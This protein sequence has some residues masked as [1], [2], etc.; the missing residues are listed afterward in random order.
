MQNIKIVEID[1]ES[2]YDVKIWATDVFLVFS[3]EWRDRRTQCQNLIDSKNHQSNRKIHGRKCEA[4][5]IS[6]T[7]ARNF[8]DNHHI[9]GS[10]KLGIVFFALLYENE[11]VAVMTLGRHSRQTSENRIV[12]DRFC[13]KS[14]VHINGGASKLFAKCVEW[15]T[16][17]KYDEII[18]FSDNRW[19]TGG[20]YQTL[21]FD[22]EKE[23]K[24]DYCYV[25]T[26]NP[27]RR[28]SK[29]SQKKTTSKCPSD[30]TE[31]QWSLQRGLRRL[32]DRGKKRWVYNINPLK[33]SWKESLSLRCAQ[34]HQKGIFRHSHVR[35]I[36]KSKNGD[37]IYYGSSYELRC[38][39][40]MDQN[41]N[42]ECFRRAD[43]FQDRDGRWRNPD[44]HVSY[45]NGDI[46]IIEVKPQSIL[47]KKTPEVEK[48]IEETKNHCLEHGFI[49]RTW[50]EIDSGL[51]DDK[52][53]I[54]WAKQYI[55]MSTGNTE[56]IE[57]QTNN[58]R[59]KAKKHYKEKV[60]TKTTTL[61]CN[62]CSLEHTVLERT[63]NRNIQRNG[64]YICKKE[65]G[66]IAG[67]QSKK[68]K[69]TMSDA[70]ECVKCKQIKDFTK[71]GK[72]K[73]RSDGYSSRCRECR[74]I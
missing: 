1:D 3:D 55:L 40:L 26:K 5:E 52:S 63:F 43:S 31:E 60:A 74:K 36:F 27:I 25:D 49:F 50:S 51:N 61:R 44:L 69:E 11:I 66:H 72:D 53:I 47:T 4:K 41:L 14:G 58:N 67:S 10:N 54:R 37:E 68:K 13:V 71:F 16:K 65:G 57:R 2:N 56:W 18:S 17:Q 33:I 9:Q 22:L 19:T 48:Q 45:K 12:L 62:Y 34:Q 6:N 35:G 15:S 7:L 59:K 73:S 70:K 28:L 39:W 46:A 64:R 42:I 30:L 29:Q 8:L 21:G 24:P 32:W 23:H 20:M 38:L